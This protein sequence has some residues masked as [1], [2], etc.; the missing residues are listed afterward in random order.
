MYKNRITKWGIHKR[1]KGR[2]V[3]LTS[4]GRSSTVGSSKTAKFRLENT[5]KKERPAISSIPSSPSAPQLLKIPEVIFTN[6][7]DYYL[8][9]LETGMWNDED[10]QWD[11]VST[12]AKGNTAGKVGHFFDRHY[13]AC[14]LLDRGLF[15]EGGR[16]LDEASA[17]IKDILA[18]EIPA[19]LPALFALIL[20]LRM[21]NRP[22]LVMLVLKQF[23]ALARILFPERHPM[24]Q[25]LKSLI[26]F[27]PLDMKQLEAMNLVSMQ[28][29]TKALIAKLGP[30]H[31]YVLRRQSKI[32]EIFKTQYDIDSAEE[33]LKEL[34]QQCQTQCGKNDIRTLDM[35]DSLSEILMQQGKYKEAANVA[36]QILIHAPTIP[37]YQQSLI[38]RVSG[39]FQMARAFYAQKKPTL[40]IES[41]QQAIDLNVLASGVNN[42]LSHRFL[43]Q[44]KDWL[45]E[46]GLYER[47]DDIGKMLKG[48]HCASPDGCR[49]VEFRSD[50]EAWDCVAN[51]PTPW[52]TRLCSPL[53]QVDPSADEVDGRGQVNP[54]YDEQVINLD[55]DV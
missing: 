1:N 11:L 25:I 19:T 18:A 54:L 48:C 13:M 52:S 26:T 24:V 53:C 9:A 42:I 27:T 23:A 14:S 15:E 17:V 36:K 28:I 7:H 33:A 30:M 6:I 47:A 16:A 31:A 8:G 12:K 20:Y 46:Q 3:S 37:S 51:P 21:A 41:L 35:L 10:G 49:F 44:M 38:L 22:E 32:I 2:L 50:V 4:S 43:L 29:S 5:S 34:V 45:S 40:A 55:I 39:S